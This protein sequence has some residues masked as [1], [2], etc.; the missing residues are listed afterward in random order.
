LVQSGSAGV[1]EALLTRTTSPAASVPTPAV[2]LLHTC[3]T[4]ALHLL[5]FN[6]IFFPAAKDQDEEPGIARTP[7]HLL[8]TCFTDALRLRCTCVAPALQLPYTCFEPA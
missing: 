8:Y 6:F 5:Y 3:F 2:H 7:E 1:A 4:P